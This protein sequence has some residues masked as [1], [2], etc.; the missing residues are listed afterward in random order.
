MT[1]SVLAAAFLSVAVFSAACLGGPARAHDEALSPERKAEIEALVRDYILQHPEII[2]ES[3]A[4]MQAREEAEK[5]NAVKQALVDNREALERDPADPVLGNPD[6]DV[7]IVEFF[8]YQCGYCKSMMQPL[9]DLVKSDGKIRLILKEF[10]ILGPASE[11]ASLASLAAA[12]QGRYTEFHT[13]LLR[14]RGRLSTEAIWQVAVETGLNLDT[15]KADMQDP[16]LQAHVRKSF[17][18]AKALEIQGT[19]AFTIGEHVIPGAVSKEQLA[20]LIAQVRADS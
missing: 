4:I 3:V 7:T 12:R 9:L 20:E 10:P 8:D 5:N 15:L 16:A 1:R 6:G 19:P 2:L 17:A 11:T 14:L 13:A 18:L